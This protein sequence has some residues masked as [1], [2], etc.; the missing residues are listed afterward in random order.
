MTLNRG[1]R[2]TGAKGGRCPSY[3]QRTGAMEGKS[4]LLI[5]FFQYNFSHFVLFSFFSQSRPPSILM[6]SSPATK[7]NNG[8]KHMFVNSNL[9][10]QIQTCDIIISASTLLQASVPSALLLIR[11]PWPQIRPHLH[12]AR[13]HKASSLETSPLRLH[14]NS[15]R[16][17]HLGFQFTQDL[18]FCETCCVIYRCVGAVYMKWS[19]LIKSA[20]DSR[21]LFH[22]RT[23]EKANLYV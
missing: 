7:Y 19:S 15:S 13:F 16:K 4:A 3:P 12:G 6:N 18:L 1:C 21:K 23:A 2:S 17:V 9:Y 11:R 5:L 10:V 8:W 22:I 20:I 14:E